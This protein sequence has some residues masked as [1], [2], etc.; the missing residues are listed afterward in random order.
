MQGEGVV[1]GFAA[2]MR[3]MVRN[4]APSWTASF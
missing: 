4:P 2:C 3:T 1:L